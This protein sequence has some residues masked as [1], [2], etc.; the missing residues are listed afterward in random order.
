MPSYQEA[1]QEGRY[2]EYCQLHSRYMPEDI[3]D[4]FHFLLHFKI[5]KAVHCHIASA[6]RT[7]LAFRLRQALS[8]CFGFL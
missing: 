3:K 7:G 8:S 5:Y 4:M 1:N 2:G 6:G